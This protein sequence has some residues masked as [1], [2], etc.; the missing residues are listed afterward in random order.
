MDQKKWGI[1]QW[2]ITAAVLF[3]IAWIVV[4]RETG[5]GRNWWGVNWD[6]HTTGELGDSF[7]VVGALMASLAAYFAFRTYSAAREEMARQEAEGGQRIFLDLLERRPQ[8]LAQVRR[9]SLEGIE[10]LDSIFGAAKGGVPNKSPVDSY[11]FALKGHDLKVSGSAAL[12][13]FTYHVVA[14]ADREFEREGPITKAHT[15]YKLVRFLRAQMTDSELGVLALNS[16]T[17]QGFG[18]KKFVERYAM[19]HNMDPEIITHFK[20]H[21]AFALTAFGLTKDDQEEALGRPLTY[22]ELGV[23]APRLA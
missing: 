3:T 15:A 6:F 19:L 1:P 5:L 11:N 17:K 16:L 18:F 8:V 21:E 20:F 10:A 9:G 13:R 23:G 2:L 4:V 22:A 14:L 12:W 7:G